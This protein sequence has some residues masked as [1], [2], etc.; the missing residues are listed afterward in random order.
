MS[1]DLSELLARFSL[2]VRP[3]L[4]QEFVPDKG[5]YLAEGRRS[6]PPSVSLARA[7]ELFRKLPF[8]FHIKDVPDPLVCHPTIA[9]R[10]AGVPRRHRMGHMCFGKGATLDDA[11]ASAACEAVERV[12]TWPRDDEFYFDAGTRILDDR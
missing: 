4:G 6:V 8:Q 11:L 2:S 10:I 12:T 9:L 7:K 3:G 1:Q 5:P